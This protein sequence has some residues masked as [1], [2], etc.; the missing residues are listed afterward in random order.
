MFFLVMSL[1]DFVLARDDV[2]LI[3]CNFGSLIDDS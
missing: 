1:S 2:M 3:P